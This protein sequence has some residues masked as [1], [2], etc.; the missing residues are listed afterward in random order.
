MKIE[1]HGD[2]YETTT[3]K[4]CHCKF[5]YTKNDI[6]LEYKEYKEYVECPECGKRKIIFIYRI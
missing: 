3:C 1:K 5:S 6:R 4:L 2:T